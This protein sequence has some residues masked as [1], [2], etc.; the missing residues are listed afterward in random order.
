MSTIISGNK[1]DPRISVVKRAG[2]PP[3]R[4]QQDMPPD[5]KDT[6]A[7]PPL[8]TKQ[9]SGKT[10]ESTDKW[11]S[12]AIPYADIIEKHAGRI[13]P[14]ISDG[15]SF[16]DVAEAEEVKSLSSDTFSRHTTPAPDTTSEEAGLDEW[17]KL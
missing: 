15:G 4:Q 14:A 1:L 6:N 12:L 9:T 7:F 10:I 8:K 11:E 2:S 16:R 17:V 3:P 13:S 5:P